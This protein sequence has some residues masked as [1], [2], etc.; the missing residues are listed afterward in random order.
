MSISHPHRE[1]PKV[2]PGLMIALAIILPGVVIIC[3]CKYI[4][5]PAGRQPDN[6]R[7]QVPEIIAASLGLGVSLGTAI[8]VYTGVKNLTGKPR[9]DF[10]SICQPDLDDVAAHTVGG[11]GQEVSRLW[12]MVDRGICKQTDRR[13]LNDAMRSFPSGYAA[14]EK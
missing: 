13:L 2:H 9:P 7:Q 10:L 11:F 1:Y 6:R 4:K 5:P 12:V 14:S 8:V 3:I